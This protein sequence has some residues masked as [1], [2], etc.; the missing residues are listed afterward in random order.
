MQ[1]MEET[2]T[3]HYLTDI[4]IYTIV[5][6]K[7]PIYVKFQVLSRC[8]ISNRHVVKIEIRVNNILS[9]SRE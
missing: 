7:S 9:F 5:K 2:N 6:R 1:S 4:F 8:Y 3:F